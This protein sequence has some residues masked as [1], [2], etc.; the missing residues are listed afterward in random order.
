MW[1]SVW[2]GCLWQSASAV[3]VLFGASFSTASVLFAQDLNLQSRIEVYVPP[4]VAQPP[5]PS[6][7]IGKSV[8]APAGAASLDLES[9]RLL[10]AKRQS[11]STLTQKKSQRPK[12][13]KLAPA[14]H[15]RMLK[16]R[17]AVEQQAYIENLS[18]DDIDELLAALIKPSPIQF[19]NSEPQKPAVKVTLPILNPTYETN[20]LKSDTNIKAD[21]SLG[22]GGQAQLT[23]GVSTARPWDIAAFSVGET[24]V[25][26]AQTPSKSFDSLSQSAAYQFFLGATDQRGDALAPGRPLPPGV[27][28]KTDAQEFTV[29]TV[30]LGVQNTTAFTP[31]FHAQTADLFTPQV[32][33][34]RQNIDL[35][36]T[37]VC[38]TKLS[39]SAGNCVYADL[40]VGLGQTFSDQ[41][42]QTNAN[43]AAAGTLGYR[44]DHSDFVFTVPTV[45][46]AKSYETYV[47]GRRDFVVQTG[48][49]LSFA[50]SANFSAS[51]A[52]TY[53]QQYS[54]VAAGAWHGWII[55]PTLSILF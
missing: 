10:R 23:T 25:R 29:D 11:L 18:A 19:W 53:Y 41:P 20:V 34:T 43:L 40:S 55:Q 44:I 1:R 7:S 26:Y 47:G 39:G 24:S 31:T 13:E 8:T 51:L 16:E 42:T 45:I 50:P 48:P 12:S 22:V 28:G 14:E 17:S 6:Q 27:N 15:I 21:S 33:L 54:S 46:T 35:S 52:A 38:R 4:F 3:L 30:L 32:V 49:A 5:A 37:A 36:G 9:I 2:R